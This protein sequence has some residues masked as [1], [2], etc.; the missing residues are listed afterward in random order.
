MH[1]FS[2]LKLTFL[3]FLSIINTASDTSNFPLGSLLQAF[4]MIMNCDTFEYDLRKLCHFFQQLMSSSNLKQIRNVTRS[5]KFV[6]F[7]EKYH[8]KY[9]ISVKTTRKRQ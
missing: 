1:V 4:S 7:L 5:L 6:F 9:F 2:F 3:H 8:F